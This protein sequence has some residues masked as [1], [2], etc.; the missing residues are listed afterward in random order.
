MEIT[1]PDSLLNDF[2]CQAWSVQDMKF[3]NLTTILA[4]HNTEMGPREI[5]F[6]FQTY[7][8]I[9]IVR[10][11]TASYISWKWDICSNI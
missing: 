11:L 7:V 3:Y 8:N 10:I 5:I 4:L 9:L 2:A 1:I 6:K